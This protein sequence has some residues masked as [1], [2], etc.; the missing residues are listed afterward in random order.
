MKPGAHMSLV[1]V[2]YNSSRLCV[3]LA[4][5]KFLWGE[6]S[7]DAGPRIVI[8]PAEC[9]SSCRRGWLA[10]S[11]S[12]HLNPRR[13][14][15]YSTAVFTIAAPR[16]SG[17]LRL[18]SRLPPVK[19]VFPI[20]PSSTFIK[21]PPFHISSLFAFINSCTHSFHSLSSDVSVASSTKSTV[22]SSASFFKFQYLVFLKVIQ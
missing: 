10:R 15:P 1:L 11:P 4:L 19:T 5:N 12:H 16:C 2:I 3:C 13:S 7:A 20:P 17:W 22:R 6:R 8:T 18:L 14:D 21:T 9:E